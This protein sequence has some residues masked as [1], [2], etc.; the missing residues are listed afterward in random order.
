METDDFARDGKADAR[1]VGFGRKEWGED[2]FGDIGGYCL[3]VVGNLNLD[4]FLCING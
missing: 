4:A 2:I 1:A 3:S